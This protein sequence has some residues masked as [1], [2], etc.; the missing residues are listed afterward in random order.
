MTTMTTKKN[1]KL[2]AEICLYGTRDAGFGFIARAADGRMFGKGE[3]F[4]G[5]SMTETVWLAVDELKTAGVSGA[6][7]ATVAIFAPGGARLA[8]EAFANVRAVGD[9]AWQTAPTFTVSVAALTA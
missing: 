7:G 9:F 4:A 8:V 3:L 1:T 6:G 5:R 2:V